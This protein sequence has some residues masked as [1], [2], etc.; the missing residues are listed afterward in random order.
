MGNSIL[1]I[2]QSSDKLFGTGAESCKE[3][4]HEF[5][6]EYHI[7]KNHIPDTD[8]LAFFLKRCPR[9]DRIVIVFSSDTQSVSIRNDV[10]W[11]EIYSSFVENLFDDDDLIV[12]IRISK[13]VENSQLSVYNLKLF[14]DFIC[15]QSYGKLFEI[16]TSLFAECGDHIVFQL[17]D[18]EGSLRTNSIAFSNY[19]V[20][21]GENQTREKSL[22]DCED[23]SVFLDRMRI[24]LI[25]SDF[26][27]CTIESDHFDKIR[28]LFQR[29]KTILSYIYIANTATIIDEKAVLQFDPSS[30]GYEFELIDISDNAA[31]PAIYEW[32]FKDD[33]C[34]D[35][36]SIARKIIN[37]YC[38]DRD[39]IL[40][41]D[42][43]ILNSIKSDYVI[44]Q[45]NHADQYIDMKN[46]IS[47]F[48]VDSAGKMQEL[49]HDFSDAFRNNFVA[50]IVFLMTV[51]L[52]DSIDFS[53]FSRAEISTQIVSVCGLFTG[54]TLLYLIATIIMGNQKW[55]WL[56]QSYTDLKKN[57][58]KVFDSKDLEEAF[59]HDEPFENA[60]AQYNTLCR[61]LG[62]V[63][64][65]LFLGLLIFTMVLSSHR[66]TDISSGNQIQIN[67]TVSDNDENAVE[68]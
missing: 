46:R 34:V 16:F 3:I 39:S 2:I 65:F 31:V 22:K 43:T 12:T 13:N 47:M 5:I 48:I 68:Q 23:A 6:C 18:T 14:S 27:I 17:L 60:K 66:N 42:D 10:A 53:D 33:S 45:N 26:Y 54:A 25:P 49:S 21:W 11:K 19:D 9:R 57:Y 51:I 32:I 64:I 7:E 59:N 24:R 28:N 52:T 50:V 1:D 35:K 67:E 40:K 56:R 37:T 58:V 38:R 36:A 29:I 61:K 62:I 55:K 4:I 15:G 30:K 44:Y 63:W 41:I 8:D 20:L